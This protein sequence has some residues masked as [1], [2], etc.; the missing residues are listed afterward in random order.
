MSILGYCYILII[1]VCFVKYAHRG[2]LFI[3][4]PLMVYA[5]LIFSDLLP[6]YLP[7]DKTIPQIMYVNTHI[8]MVIN[9]FFL[10]YYRRHY[11]K[12]ISIRITNYQYYSREN[13]RYVLIFL[14]IILYIISGV[15]SGT[16][17]GFLRGE[18]MEDMR[19][20][21]EIG[22]G[23]LRDIPAVGCEY[24]LLLIF[25]KYGW[26]KSILAGCVLFLIGMTF[27]ISSGGNRGILLTFATI[28]LCFMAICKRGLK[29]YEYL[30]WQ[31]GFNVIGAILNA[32]RQAEVITYYIANFSWAD[33]VC[34]YQ[35]IVFNNS[36]TLID[37]TKRYG[38]FY[39]QEILTN[40]TYFIPRFIWP[41]KPISFGYKMKEL[42]NYSFAG[43]GIMP[44]T[45]EY[46]YINWGVFWLVD[47]I[48]WIIFLNYLYAK[49]ITL[50]SYKYKLFIILLLISVSYWAHV[51]KEIEVLFL[52]WIFLKIIYM[53]FSPQTIVNKKWIRKK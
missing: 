40:L 16:L 27:L 44:S 30:A 9:L 34:G 36:I 50:K 37:V 4:S 20:T 52:F 14:F 21:G 32:L 26:R 1:V 3:F 28:F 48:L 11:V 46:S 39:G 12:K 45:I 43:G 23:F 35:N 33:V 24:L 29:F 53:M 22:V 2:T 51:A 8:A 41:D 18:D 42:A 38:F 7:Q 17:T 10:F 25:I 47:Y 5:S 49:L 15:I 6:L 13:I 31:I 19:R